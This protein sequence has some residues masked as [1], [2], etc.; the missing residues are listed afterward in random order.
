MHVTLTLLLH[1]YYMHVL[2]NVHATEGYMQ[3]F[4]SRVI[5]ECTYMDIVFPSSPSFIQITIRYH[6]QLAEMLS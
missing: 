2:V 1:A 5:S 4:S 6:W 3:H